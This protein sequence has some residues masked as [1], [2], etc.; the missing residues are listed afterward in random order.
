[1]KRTA[2]TLTQKNVESKSNNSKEILNR[3]QFMRWNTD[4]KERRQNY[5]ELMMK[6]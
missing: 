1:M 3:A 2:T 5:R 4:I 6:N